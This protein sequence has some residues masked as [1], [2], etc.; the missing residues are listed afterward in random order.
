MRNTSRD[1]VLITRTTIVL[2]AHRQVD[3]RPKE[4]HAL[5]EH[6]R[7]YIE[8][9]LIR[10][11]PVP[12]ACVRVRV[13]SQN[14]FY[15]LIPRELQPRLPCCSPGKV[16][17]LKH[18]FLFFCVPSPRHLSATADRG[19]VRAPGPSNRPHASRRPETSDRFWSR[20]KTSSARYGREKT[21]AFRTA[22]VNDVRS[23][24]IPSKN[25]S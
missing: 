16:L 25:S 8:I 20:P 5:V 14:E 22:N 2:Y 23:R 1:D 18:G 13:Y 9:P 15:W 4:L 10:Y 7:W 21:E 6:G 11:D 24:L 3:V 12:S 19:A 17:S